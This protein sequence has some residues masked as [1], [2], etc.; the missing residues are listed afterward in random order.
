M[1]SRAR[2]ENYN[3]ESV[4]RTVAVLTA[5]E[6]GDTSSLDRV[7][8]RSGLSESTA[9]RYLSS[10]ATHGL[11][12]RDPLSGAYRL[13][14]SLFRLGGSAIRQRDI[15]SVAG[16]V[17]DELRDRF[18]ET[19][20]IGA[21]DGDRVVVVHVVQSPRSLRKGATAG[22]V[23]S[24]HATSLG[25]AMLAE[26]PDDERDR[27]IG[28]APL[29][30]FTPNTV[31]DHEALHRDLRAVRTRGYAIDDEETDE[32]LRCVGAVIRDH[33]GRPGYAISVSGPK[34]RMP[35]PRL[36]EIGRTLV[37]AAARLSTQ[38]GHTA[39]ADA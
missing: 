29:I 38:L 9:L 21:R 8:Q 15:T 11:V 32:G 24:W 19:V 18:E 28:D 31:A 17:A 36:D 12:E 6:G 4:A 2:P 22:G 27:L 37:T 20:N 3:L 23:D 25:K 26:L 34:S 5:L 39:G 7:S 30:R 10:L 16:P 35:V 1:P 33:A 13:G 14:L